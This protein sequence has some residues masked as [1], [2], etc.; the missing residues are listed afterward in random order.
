MT[1]PRYISAA[2]LITLI[3]LMSCRELPSESSD[4]EGLSKLYIY[5]YPG[6]ANLFLD[7]I[8]TGKVTPDSV[9]NLRNGA[10]KVSLK[11]FGYSDT[12]FTVI[13]DNGESE[14]V[15]VELKQIF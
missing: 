2:I 5:T 15:T 13:L 10:Y 4:S 8:S 12:T 11:L 3:V 6:G 1:L 7:G 14:R 9:V